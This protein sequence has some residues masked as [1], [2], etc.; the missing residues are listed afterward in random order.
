M[1]SRAV[2]D[3]AIGVIMGQQRCTA[4]EAFELLRTASQHRNT[5]L[6]DLCT[7]LITS[8]TNR[9]PPSEPALRPRA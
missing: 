8:I 1:Q 5:K 7:D 2:I 9:P 3:Q 6:R 4:E